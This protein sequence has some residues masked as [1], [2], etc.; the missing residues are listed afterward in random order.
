MHSINIT[1]SV[2]QNLRDIA[3]ADT[4]AGSAGGLV[5]INRLNRRTAALMMFQ[6]SKNVQKVCA[7]VLVGLMFAAPL[8]RYSGCNV[9]FSPKRQ[10]PCDDRGA[11]QIADASE[12]VQISILLFG[13][14]LI[15]T[16]SRLCSNIVRQAPP[17]YYHRNEV[18]HAH[19][20]KIHTLSAVYI[21]HIVSVAVLTGLLLPTLNVSYNMNGSIGGGIYAAMILVLWNAAM[22]GEY[23][24]RD[25]E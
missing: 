10:M 25:T 7:T 16:V 5:Y 23:N 4:A 8:F 22:L 19:S 6:L 3:C 20:F 12:N 1:R 24:R 13:S 15:R 17:N 2:P 14:F 9:V 21:Y 18:A 11:V